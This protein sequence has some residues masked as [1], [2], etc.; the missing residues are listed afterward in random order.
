MST[1]ESKVA[2]IVGRSKEEARG[3]ES[4]PVFG[5]SL[6]YK[7]EKVIKSCHREKSFRKEHP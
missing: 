5:P 3:H 4:S 7:T 2:K 1:S 6:I